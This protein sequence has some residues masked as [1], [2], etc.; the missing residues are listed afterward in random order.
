MELKGSDAK[1]AATLDYLRKLCSTREYCRRDVYEKAL[2]RLEGDAEEAG[3]VVESLVKDKF[4]DEIR[5]ASAFARDKASIQGWG[6]L[7][8]RM[9]LSAKGVSADVIA[10][11]LESIDDDKADSKLKK[12]LEIKALQLKEDP[13]IRLKLLRFAL[14]RGYDYSKVNEKISEVLKK[15]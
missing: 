2:K 3:R 1:F 14:G 5:Y 12:S 8:I 6:P 11:S 10:A 9:A 13:Q 15:R 4:I 7:K